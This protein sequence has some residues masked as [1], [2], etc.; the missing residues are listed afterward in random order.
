M[1]HKPKILFVFARNTGDNS[2]R[3][4]GF[5]KRIAKNGGFSY[6]DVDYVALEDLVFHIKNKRTARIYDPVAG[7]DVGSY[8]F[9]YLKSW[10]SLPELAASVAHFLEGKGI[11]YADHQARHEYIAKTTNY[12]TMWSHGVAV[13]ETWWGSRPVLEALTGSMDETHFPLIIKAVHGQKGKDNYLA[14]DKQSALEILRNTQVDMLL[15]QFIPNDG[16][17][18][19]GVYGHKARWAIYRQ[20][21]GK[22]HLNNTSAGAVATNLA[23]KDVPRRLRTLAEAAADACDLAISGV[24]V[25]ED[26]VTKKIYVL[27]ANQGSQI[28]TGAFTDTN[29]TAFDEGIAAMVSRRFKGGE[30]NAGRL[31]V[32]GRNLVVTIKTPDGD[33]PMRAKVDTGA[34]QSAVDATEVALSTDEDG[35]E[36]VEYVLEDK[37][38][39]RRVR[40]RSYDFGRARIYSSTGHV[41]IRY[42][43][44]MTLEIAGKE[45]NTRVTLARRTNHK[46]QVLMGRQLLRGHFLV[47]VELGL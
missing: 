41:D 39:D 34:Y 23:V 11:P 15:Q 6:A 10:Q 43:V 38:H 31:R 33:M 37:V 35:K 27:E 18:R 8:S 22:S 14:R 45:Y 9:V 1:T 29:M 36:Y 46:N 28:V 21:S 42:V 30:A 25:V 24:D 4:G 16:D 20:S 32:I 3:F 2:T 7:V 5:V 19:I 44:P 12:M 13:P 26:K 17:Y 47:N 40:V